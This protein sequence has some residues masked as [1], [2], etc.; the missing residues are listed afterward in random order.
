M[1]D[2]FISYRHS[3]KP[4]VLAFCN[5]LDEA[6]LTFY[7]DEDRRN[8]DASIQRSIESGLAASKLLLAWFDPTY[9][10]SKACTWE[11]G[12]ALLA[13]RASG[14]QRIVC[15]DPTGTFD[16][17]IPESLADQARLCSE[18]SNLISILSSRLEQI[19]GPMGATRAQKLLPHWY[20]REPPRHPGW[21]GRDGDL[22]RLFHDLDKGRLGMYGYVKAPVAITG[23]G[24]EG[25]TMLAEQYALRFAAIYPAGIIWLAGS[26]ED[27]VTPLQGNWHERLESSLSQIAQGK[28][29]IFT[30]DLLSGVT[31]P[32]ER[33]TKLKTAIDRKLRRRTRAQ[34]FSAE[35]LWIVDDLPRS[36][37]TKYLRLWLPSDLN[38][39]CIATIREGNPIDTGFHHFSVSSLDDSEALRILGRRRRPINQQER[40]CAKEIISQLGNLPL[41]LELCANLVLIQGYK[42]FLELLQEPIDQSLERLINSLE[43]A[44]PTGHARSIVKT[45]ERS[46]ANLPGDD[47]EISLSDNRASWIVLRLAALI[48]PH[49][50]P[51]RLAV[52]VITAYG[53]AEA[54][55]AFEIA[56]VKL[57]S[58]AVIR[59]DSGLDPGYVYIHALLARTV[60]EM[61]NDIRQYWLLLNHSIEAIKFWLEEEAAKPPVDVDWSMFGITLRIVREVCV[62]SAKTDLPLAHSV[63]DDACFLADEVGLL[64]RGVGKFSDARV[65]FEQGFLLRASISGPNDRRA[66]RSLSNIA[67]TVLDQ[68]DL[69]GAKERLEQLFLQTRR[70]FSDD[71]P[72]TWDAANN[73]AQGLFAMGEFGRALDL[74]R[75]VFNLQRRNVGEMD[76]NTLRS[77]LNLALFMYLQENEEDRL[78]S[79][80][81][82]EWLLEVRRSELGLEHPDTLS[83]MRNLALAKVDFGDFAGALRLQQAEATA[84]TKI[85]GEENPETL[86]CMHNLALT[87]KLQGNAREAKNTLRRAWRRRRSVL[88]AEHIETLSSLHEFANILHSQK[89]FCRAK[90]LQIKILEARSANLGD[91]HILTLGSKNSLAVTLKAQGH[92]GEARRLFQ[93]VY[94]VHLQI[95]PSRFR[96]REVFRA[97]LVSTMYLMGDSI[98]VEELQAGFTSD[99]DAS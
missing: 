29:G 26:T 19:D 46:L 51:T 42:A 52:R 73:Y 59:G 28:L 45:F 54:R 9:L 5:L 7:R 34:Q 53:Y 56:R 18:P 12:Q 23:W 62:E 93:E 66:I 68:G 35:Y 70:L 94:D 8:D 41:A 49:P 69:R 55:I 97:N 32:V 87:L 74:Q 57:Q 50:L 78:K 31:E 14:L 65:L 89:Y 2:I 95:Y 39:H 92:L 71:D 67:C 10:Q 33:I 25:K 6:K 21:V 96:E 88:G 36:A 48:S 38:V 85:L 98:S 58:A 11:L 86:S 27:G 16:H 4:G 20:E 91:E 40:M 43:T 80:E 13:S 99:E 82:Q 17:I 83:S 22:L 61:R 90:L 75:W 84:R 81:M 44:L 30:D 77:Y 72:D 37:N 47:D 63:A 15:I 76:E 3:L 24:G 60:H 64:A 1:Y 79:V